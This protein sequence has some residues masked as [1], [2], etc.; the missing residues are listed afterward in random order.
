MS[1]MTV[2]QWNEAWA[3]LMNFDGDEIPNP[4]PRIGMLLNLWAE[5]VPPEALRIGLK[6]RPELLNPSIRYNRGNN[7]RSKR[8]EHIIE[9]QILTIDNLLNNEIID[10][11][12]ALALGRGQIGDGSRNKV[13]ADLAL[14]TSR[15]IIIGEVKVKA[16]NPW[17]AL[18]E[19]L[20]QLKLA[21]EQ[22][23]MIVNLFKE[24][25]HCAP[26]IFNNIPIIS[27]V[28][29]PKNYYNSPGQKANSLPWTK[30]LSEKL[31]QQYN[32]KAELLVWEDNK[33]SHLQID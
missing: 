6:I 4:R 16:N 2:K 8:A 3:E 33:L 7:D 32:V 26:E 17:Y 10:G 25:G 18:I 19:N 21:I 5:V 9:N 29:A 13:E 1:P 12:N 27:A 11:L 28:I 22:R 20:K 14:V 24:R 23:S 30:K 31:L 15:N